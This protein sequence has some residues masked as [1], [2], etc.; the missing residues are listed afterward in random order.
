MYFN[1][2]YDFSKPRI[3]IGRCFVILCSSIKHKV[4]VVYFC[5]LHSGAF[6]TFC[7]RQICRK[8]EQ[9]EYILRLQQT[10]RQQIYV[11]Q[12]Q[13]AQVQ[14]CADQEICD[15]KTR[16]NFRLDSFSLLCFEIICFFQL[17]LWKSL[18]VLLHLCFVMGVESPA[19]C[20]KIDLLT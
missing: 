11:F 5:R 1:N 2:P 13:C 15:T 10:L 20:P 12:F 18:S 7:M 19:V 9:H 16:F 14:F 17:T 8:Y 4:F 3:R 6:R